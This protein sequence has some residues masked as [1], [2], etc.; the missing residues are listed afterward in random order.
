MSHSHRNDPTHPAD[1]RLNLEG[2]HYLLTPITEAGHAWT[3]Q[4]LAPGTPW[5][6]GSAEVAEQEVNALVNRMTD[7]GLA[8]AGPM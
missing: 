5:R 2:G 1:I 4:H 8:V 3:A 7:A 6:G